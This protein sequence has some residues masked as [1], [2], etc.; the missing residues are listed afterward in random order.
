MTRLI[1]L[2]HA[3]FDR[4]TAAGDWITPTLARLVFVAT[5]LQY[6]WASGLTK[7]G[8][9]ITGL[10]VPA[11]GAYFQIFPKAIEAVGYD[12]SQLGT[13]HWAVALAGTW[14]EFILPFLILIGLFT[15][16]AALGM[17]GF[18]AVQTWV[19]IFGHGLGAADI[20]VWFDNIPGSLIVDQR[21]FWLFVLIVL[22]VRGGGPLSADRL[23]RK[24]TSPAHLSS[25]PV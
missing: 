11:D 14:A 6:F 20:G 19:D 25:T 24:S 4:L 15:R 22:V 9:G 5:L 16:L 13:F 3:I 21:A 7:L 17:I 18:I 23:L 12:P 1:T 2:H 8:D 10:F